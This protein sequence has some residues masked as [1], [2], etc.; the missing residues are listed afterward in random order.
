VLA[1]ADHADDVAE[2]LKTISQAGFPAAPAW[3]EKLPVVGARMAS[4]WQGLAALSPDDLHTL[5]APHVRNAAS[6]TLQQAGGLPGIL[7]HVLLTVILA[8]LLYAQ[9]EAAAAGLRAFAGRLAGVRGVQ[10]VVLAGQSIRAVALGVLA[11]AFIQAV[12]SG[13]GL[14][15]A[16]VPF[17]G[18]L[19]ALI[20][21]LGVAQIPGLPVMLLALGWLYWSGHTWTA[22]LFL[23]WAIFAGS[24]DN[25]LKPILI[26]RG[27]DLPLVLIFAGVIGGLL[28]FGVV[29]LFV[30]PVVLAI[31]YTQLSAWVADGV[32]APGAVALPADADADEQLPLPIEATVTP[33]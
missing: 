30:G 2:R 20:F 28:A 1:V 15:V 16:G 27:A 22:L 9:G 8:V 33:P 12:L 7:L 26:K 10:S 21:V 11:T 5:M 6:W 17:A 25:I 24:L 29:G 32:P 3:V 13:L 18:A 19:T 31:A 14:A 23:P 4:K